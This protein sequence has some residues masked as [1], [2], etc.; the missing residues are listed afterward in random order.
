MNLKNISGKDVLW[1]PLPWSEWNDTALTVHLFTQVIGKIRLALMPMEV[2]WAQVP[3]IVTSRGLASIGMPAGFGSLDITFDF[4]SHS[5]NF[6][7]SDGRQISFALKGYSVADFYANVQTVLNDLNVSIKINPMSVEMPNPVRLDLDKHN[8]YDGDTVQRW[9]HLLVSI[10]FVFEEFRS[11]FWG[12]QSQ[13]SFFWGSFDLAVVRYS[14]K[15]AN[16]PPGA[17]LIYRVAMDAEQFAVGF[18]PGDDSAPEPI[19]I[20]NPME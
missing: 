12:K 16:P 19:F 15:R 4:I 11:G 14:G 20:Q 3:L 6:C 10:A 1:P 5:I 7:A 2:E 13:V 17:D 8:S 9:W 18:W